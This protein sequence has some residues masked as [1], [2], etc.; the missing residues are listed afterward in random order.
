MSIKISSIFLIE[1]L[2]T[3][4]NDLLSQTARLIYDNI[5]SVYCFVPSAGIEIIRGYRVRALIGDRRVGVDERLIRPQWLQ[6]RPSNIT[7]PRTRCSRFSFNGFCNTLRYTARFHH[8]LLC[9]RGHFHASFLRKLILHTEPPRICLQDLLFHFV[10]IST[11]F[12]DKILL[13]QIENGSH[14][15]LR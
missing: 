15:I 1:N 4:P 7:Q 9:P 11:C 2:F 10:I 14:K 13:F 12:F 3:R 6:R 5:M 8:I